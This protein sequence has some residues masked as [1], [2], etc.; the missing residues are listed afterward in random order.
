MRGVDSSE[1]K[2]V[3]QLAAPVQCPLSHS[4]T[5]WAPAITK[6]LLQYLSTLTLLHLIAETHSMQNY[7]SHTH[8]FALVTE[9]RE[10]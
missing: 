5:H 4:F 6:C 2:D 8:T 3:T 10:L 7:L 9:K 1:E